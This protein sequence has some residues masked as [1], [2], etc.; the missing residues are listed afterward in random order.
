MFKAFTKSQGRLYDSFFDDVFDHLVEDACADLEG[1]WKEDE[2]E[3]FSDRLYKKVRY[4]ILPIDRFNFTLFLNEPEAYSRSEFKR[5]K[6]L[7]EK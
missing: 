2:F 5:V 6:R 4:L 7:L 1:E 3:E